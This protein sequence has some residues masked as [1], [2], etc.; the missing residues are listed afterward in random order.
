MSSKPPRGRSGS[1]KAMGARPLSRAVR[2]GPVGDT[3][4]EADLGGG[5]IDFDVDSDV[6]ASLFAHVK[7]G[8]AASGRSASEERGDE[9]A[10]RGSRDGEELDA[11][12][13]SAD[14]GSVDD[15]DAAAAEAGEDDAEGAVELVESEPVV[16][17]GPLPPLSNDDARLYAFKRN[18][19]VAA[20]AGTGKTYRLTALYLLLTLG[21][22]SSGQ[23]GP[24]FAA[25]A[26]LPD[27]IV[28][29]T[30]SRAAAAEIAHRIESVLRKIAGWDGRGEIPALPEVI[31]AREATTG[32][33]LS[34][35][36]LKKRAGEALGRWGAARIDTLHGV[37]K[38]IVDR[39]AIAM[40]LTPGA[41]ILDEEEAQALSDLA[42]DEALSAALA[43]GGERGDAARAMLA[44]AG[45]V[46][47]ARAQITR[48][49]DRLDEE[50]L[51]PRTLALTD[52]A[53]EARAL[54]KEFARVAVALATGGN[55]KL[56]APANTLAAALRG[57]SH[58]A[59]L[60]RGA[61][62]PAV[63]L[64]TTPKRGKK[65]PADEA[66]V[67]FCEELPGDTL[68]DKA[69]KL[70]GFLRDAPGLGRR[71]QLIV[72]LLEEVKVRL[73]TIRRTEG[74]LGFGDL[75][76]AARD[77]LRDDVGVGQA[78]RDQVDVLLVDEFQDTS[79]V[80]RDLVY[81]LREREDAARMRKPG[82]APT[83]AGLSEHGLFL[84]GD[85][86]QSIYGFRGA[87]V[88][89]F[90]RV[91]A[92]LAGRT[93][94]EALGLPESLWSPRPVADFV[95]LN[96]SR[97][98][99]P[100]VLR[101]VNEF[102]VRDF[103][104]D[105]LGAPAGAPVRD[106]EVSYGTAEHLKPVEGAT[107][108]SSDVVL[109]GDDGE[110]PEDAESLVRDAKGPLREAL[111]AA[112]WVAKRVR[113][114]GG[115]LKFKDVAV[116]ARRRS[117][118]PLIEL[119]LG[120]LSVPYVVAGR[121]LFD[122]PEIRDTAAALR[123]L[124]DPGDQLAL[125]TVLRG[126][127]VG[128]SDTALAILAP[129]GRGLTVPLL[130]RWPARQGS[131]EAGSAG[132]AGGAKGGSAD[133][134]D[135]MTAS[136]LE[137]LPAQDRTRLEHFRSKFS[138]L[139]RAA[140]RSSPGEAIRA[141]IAAFDL[142]RVLAA[143]PRADARIGNLDRL[144]AIAR[145]RGGSLASF[146]RWLDRRISDE[147]DE[148]EA[149]VFSQEDDAVRLTT[150]HASKGL[151]FAAVVVV[152]LNAAPMPQLPGLGFVPAS[153][154]RPASLFV[155]HYA[156]R[157]DRAG[158]EGSRYEAAVEAL[159]PLYAVS[160]PAMKEAREEIHARER[161]ERQRLS[162]VAI[163]RAKRELVLVGPAAKPRKGSAWL[164][165]KAAFDAE[166]MPGVVR[167]VLD[168][169]ALL[170]GAHAPEAG[171][172][173]YARPVTPFRHAPAARLAHA[174]TVAIDAGALALFQECPR[175]FR[176]RHLLGVEEPAPKAQ[177]GLFDLEGPAEV[178]GEERVELMEGADP[179]PPGRAAHRV[180]SR[181]PLQRWGV[182]TKVGEVM[183]RLSA[184]GMGPEHPEAMRLA[185]GIAAFLDGPYARRVRV[186]QAAV[187]GDEA[188]T[189]GVDPRIIERGR[190]AHLSVRW[191]ADLVVDFPDGSVDVIE[192][193]RARPRTNL[194]AYELVLR[195]DALALHRR[196]EGRP[197]RAGV[198][199]L[200]SKLE[201]TW[202]PAQGEGGALALEEHERFEQGLSW[203]AQG[204]AEA[205][206]NER[207]EPVPVETCRRLRCGFIE[208][209]HGEKDATV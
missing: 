147:A 62:G 136:A 6:A 131:A 53:A 134:T 152:D 74:G 185:Q 58:D 39:H 107:P 15:G 54:R 163:T 112:A 102:S 34:P 81:L 167:T 40:G 191:A 29:T 135:D 77:G 42:V 148:P 25:K 103:A 91:C 156:R 106:F 189:L 109:I 170:Q 90:S 176:L 13:G 159:A 95:A 187:L 2:S 78:V 205:R 154:D 30:F 92:E 11:G 165:L 128:L 120:R 196:S 57:V 114:G 198:L 9:R 45:G 208:I 184:E 139:R 80:Q 195:V 101:F 22:T 38:Q 36:E 10:L 119:A 180:L 82:D 18:V 179:R 146:V 126:P 23:L 105:R 96:E 7:P 172:D 164:T 12:D 98:S 49:L 48:L 132:G 140:L 161:A 55:P 178:P 183:E 203:L 20:S 193:R 168:A 56:Q 93:A 142:D 44:A 46:D 117:T 79:A 190:G 125:A 145:R 67:A 88:S 19:V 110:A 85:R 71:E 1:A 99:T 35:E 206:G 113:E 207:W 37:A 32:E 137:R 14:G 104:Q 199:F 52:H 169:K 75:L 194:S 50:G 122:A 60:P 153:G 43:E 133:A 143:L 72:E 118:I 200:G 175:R 31:R 73:A 197:I 209:C 70:L 162:Y 129:P 89:V 63:E 3:V 86:K 174:R 188:F 26:V 150:I 144:V 108:P 33:F 69:H 21:L 61:W 157:M 151:D 111:V 28:A 115:E 166:A 68:K 94:G 149:A 17:R 124:L 8:A 83:A 66:F 171:L 4:F 202:L 59:P 84:V 177:L 5:D 87:D 97:R 76:R 121:A 141:A 186:E 47:V 130:G 155:Q 204:F 138:G 192:L 158:R 201:P 100:E 181:W 65:T 41:R 123:L 173:V 27:R 64:I 182:P 127:M 16:P 160:T 51:T 24:Q 116:L